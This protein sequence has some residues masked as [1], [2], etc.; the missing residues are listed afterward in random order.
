MRYSVGRFDQRQVPPESCTAGATHPGT[1]E[2]TVGPVGSGW[3]DFGT[4]DGT[5]YQ[6]VVYAENEFFCT[7]TASGAIETK[8]A[9]GQADATTSVEARGGQKD[10]R[11]SNLLVVSGNAVRFEVRVNGAGAWKQ[12]ANGDWLS[13]A[14]DLSVY[15]NAQS[16]E[17]RGCRD[18]SPNFCGPPST[19]DVTTPINARAAIVSCTIGST[20]ETNPPPNGNVA[21]VSYFYSFDDGGVDGFGPYAQAGVAP[22]PA[23]LGSGETRVRVQALVELAD[24]QTY[25]D[26][27]FDELRGQCA[28]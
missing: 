8:S 13:S 23:L 1:G 18:Q 3:V 19:P 15:G 6:Y 12:V 11:V 5:R 26:E 9:P 20:P 14:Q 27:E 28:P 17:Y 10:I 24:G 22:S 21:Q 7:P 16:V 25:R 2:G 4:S